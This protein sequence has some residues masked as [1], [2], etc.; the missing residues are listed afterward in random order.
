MK[1]KAT[2]KSIQNDQQKQCNDDNDDVYNCTDNDDDDL[3]KKLDGKYFTF[4]LFMG[5]LVVK[6]TSNL[7]KKYDVRLS[8]KKGPKIDDYMT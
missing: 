8:V 2:A 5:F 1:A 3:W 4:M 6:K 7:R